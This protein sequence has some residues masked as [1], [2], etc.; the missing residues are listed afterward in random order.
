MDNVG[1]MAVNRGITTRGKDK[2]SLQALY[3]DQGRYLHKPEHVRL[4]TCFASVKSR[5][6][7]EALTYCQ[8]DVEAHLILHSIHMGRP[9]LTE[10]VQRIDELQIGMIVDIM[11]Y[12]RLIEAIAQGKIIKIGTSLWGNNDRFKVG[13]NQV[14]LE[15]RKVFKAR[16]V[17]HY[18]CDDTTS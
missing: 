1:V 5:S 7:Q 4:G 6:S 9:D 14:L 12:S 3:R 15:V 11:P 10:R 8:L 16:G 2:T 13:K 17:M 18:P